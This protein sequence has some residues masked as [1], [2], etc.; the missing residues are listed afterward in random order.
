MCVVPKV[1]RLLAMTTLLRYEGNVECGW[2]LFVLTSFSASFYVCLSLSV[3]VSVC[4]SFFSIYVC[5]SVIFLLCMSV[6]S[7]SLPIYICLSSSF[8]MSDVFVLFHCLPYIVSFHLCLSIVISFHLCLYLSIREILC[9]WPVLSLPIL[10]KILSQPLIFLLQ[11]HPY[12]HPPSQ[13]LLAFAHTDFHEQRQEPFALPN[14]SSRT[15]LLL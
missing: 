2:L 9:I 5:L 4:L 7:F 10:H 6:L 13:H 1:S 14:P 3:S 8:S 11:S 15:P 12:P